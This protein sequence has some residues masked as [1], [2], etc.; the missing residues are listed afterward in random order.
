M[1]TDVTRI[2]DLKFGKHASVSD[3]TATPGTLRVIQP[4][5]ATIYPRDTRRLE[6]NLASPDNREFAAIIGPQ[7]LGAFSVTQLM[8][9][10]SG[11]VG[12][13][14]VAGT[15]ME[16]ADMLDVVFGAAAS[17]PVGAAVTVAAAGHVPGTGT[18]VVVGTTV[19][20]GDMILFSVTSGADFVAREVVSGGGTTTLV[21]DRAYVGT[22]TT[23]STVIR[24]A[25][26]AVD[27]S[28]HD[29]IHGG[30]VAEGEDWL[31]T[32]LGCQCE[33][34]ELNMSEGEIVRMITSWAPTSFAPGNDAALSF[35]SPTF[36]SEIVAVNA[37]LWIAGVEYLTQSLSLKVTN[38]LRARK[39]FAGANGQLGY[40]VTRVPE[41]MLSG[42]IY[43]GDNAASIGEMQYDAG[44]PSFRDLTESA[45][46]RDIAV[47]VG[48]SAGA[49]MYLR[50]PAAEVRAVAADSEGL[51]MWQITANAKKPASGTS[52]RLGVF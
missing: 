7:D 18:L 37:A 51:L 2:L 34:F 21:L 43:A 52:F 41:V 13:A 8:R 47:Q 10:V 19:A 45:T 44:T 29:R 24:A 5:S 35:V 30:F 31:Q 14:F 32:I 1:S 3:W 38:T 22:P 49:A 28:I 48:L 23:G 15:T 46:S 6:R 26:W 39:T 42:M 4:E 12:A 27:P 20:N 9:G 33:S 25:R 36:G 50:I 11:N 40:I 17:V 16:Q